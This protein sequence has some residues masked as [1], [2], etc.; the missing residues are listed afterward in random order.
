MSELLQV[1]AGE[2]GTL[3][4][5]S[6]DID[7]SARR[8]ILAPKPDT[9]PTGAALGAL[10]GLDWIDPENADLFD[11]SELDDLGLSGFLSQGA[12]I[13]DDDLNTHRQ[14]LDRLEGTVLIVYARGFGGADQRLSPAPAVT[15]VLLLEEAKT[16]IHFEPLEST[17]AEG[18]LAA[19][20]QTAKNPHLT[21]LV[22][23]LALPIL[24]LLIGAVLWGVLG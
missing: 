14:L 24:A 7:A 3:R 16:A 23:I 12:G 18:Q 15:P 19:S 2:R 9:A 10:L 6:V 5:F 11:T 17:A 1:D 22:A 20:A 13:S 21:V 4:I 8:K